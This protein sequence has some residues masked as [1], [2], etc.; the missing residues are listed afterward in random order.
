MQLGELSGHFTFTVESRKI[1][2]FV[3]AAGLT[4]APG[5]VAPLGFSRAS[6]FQE[7][8]EVP[9]ST[10]LGYE[11]SRLRHAGHEWT[12]A[13]PLLEGRAYRVSGWSPYD[14]TT[15]INRSGAAVRFVTV[16]RTFHDASD[17][18]SNGAPAL[19]ESMTV[20]V[21]AE[22]PR[23]TE[24]PPEQPPP[25]PAAEAAA[26]RPWRRTTRPWVRDWRAV[27]PGGTLAEEVVGPFTVTDFVRFAGAVGDFTPIHH[28]PA[29]ARRAGL[30]GVIAMGMLPGAI[31]LDLAAAGLGPD[32][33]RR[34]GLRFRSALHVGEELTL[35]ATAAREPAAG[36]RA[37]ELTA[38][39][40]GGREVVRGHAATAP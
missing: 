11:P 7:P 25:P 29:A 10:W 40:G 37:I 18:A 30:P 26:P 27:P 31:L 32:R 24:P 4:A 21:A 1:A 14:D 2:E 19:T 17:G 23:P 3:R 36:E 20:A 9:V 38:T 15:K 35:R 16:R 28:D 34:C 8:A 12:F 6:V 22:P 33:V 39:A 13:A 5:R